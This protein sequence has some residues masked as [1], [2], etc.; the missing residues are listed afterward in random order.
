MCL[1][2]TR[3]HGAVRRQHGDP[4]LVRVAPHRGAGK[5]AG[6]LEANMIV[7]FGVRDEDLPVRR[8][9]DH[10]VEH[11]PDAA[12]GAAID[13]ARWV[14][15]RIDREHV[16]V[17]Q[18]IQDALIPDLRRRIDP[19]RAVVLEDDAGHRLEPGRW[20]VRIGPVLE[21]DRPG[22]T[23]GVDRIRWRHRLGRREVG[24]QRRD[25]PGQIG[26]A[27]LHDRAVDRGRAVAGEHARRIHA[28]AVR[29]DRKRAGCV[30]EQRELGEPRTTE[31]V[32]EVRGIEDP[33]IGASDA[34]GQKLWI[35]RIVLPAVSGRDE[36]ALA[37]WSREHDVSRLVTNEQ[38]PDDA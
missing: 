1:L 23:E 29:R 15:H 21:I 22:G 25:E 10:V 35:V 33:D 14:R 37:L 5:L 30:G 11:G 27:A 34:R 12:P 26:E 16:L 28:R 31:R 3:C 9:D 13:R 36:R 17:G 6:T 32:A 20:I 38:C 2:R 19:M 18:R 24:R 7:R 4:A 8:I